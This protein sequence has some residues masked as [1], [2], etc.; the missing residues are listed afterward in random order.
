MKSIE[1]PSRKT[2][3]EAL[4]K[5]LAIL[6]C[7]SFE[8]PEL[9]LKR[10]NEK[11]GLYKSRILR[12]CGTL[13]NEGYLIRLN[14]AA[15]RLGPKLMIL[16]KIYERTNSL[17]WLSRPILK[18]LSGL[19]GDSVKLFVIKGSKRLC[20]V[21]EEGTYRLRYALEEGET[22]VL[23]AGAGGKVLL[24]YASE[25]FRDKILN[26]SLKKITPSTIVNLRQLENEFERIRQ[27]GYGFSEGE[28]FPGVAALSAPVY[29]H[30]NKVCA[31]LTITGPTQRFSSDRRPEMLK[32]LLQSAQKL[33]LL[34]GRKED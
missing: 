24:A 4:V 32:G 18:D 28:T 26:K 6:E 33:S 27:Q 1:K 20:F 8:E 17:S 9:T 19:T 23:Y 13:V 21:A 29:N 11:T 7:F 14:S 15:Y 30:E 25:Q 5:A 2:Q 31:A 10:L 22:Q 3:V 34:L 12:L 16:G